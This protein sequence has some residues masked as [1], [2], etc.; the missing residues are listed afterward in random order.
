M[1]SCCLLTLAV[2][3][4][5]G[6]GGLST[7]ALAQTS[8]E[9]CLKQVVRDYDQPLRM[10]PADRIP[11]VLP[12][13]FAPDDVF[14][15]PLVKGRTVLSGSP[16]GYKLYAE[17]T[18]NSTHTLGRPIRLQWLIRMRLW[19][20]NRRGK[21]KQL[22]GKKNQHVLL[23]RDVDR[24]TLAVRQ[25]PGV[26]RFDLEIRKQGR[27]LNHYFQYL[28]VLPRR[29]RSKLKVNQQAF[30]AGEVAIGQLQNLGTIPI[31]VT[32]WAYLAVERFDGNHWISVMSEDMAFQLQE[33]VLLAGRAGRC[34]R[35][36]ISEKTVPGIYR[37]RT[38]IR[39]AHGKRSLS[40]V[41][42]VH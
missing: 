16:I 10:F 39:S 18:G 38:T 6:T 20:V 2:F 37:F 13:S 31:F 24:P 3:A 40:K 15:R 33:V 9:F 30:Q 42:S 28:R 23:L 41:F 5:F 26:Y 32:S 29:T 17:R 22:V 35:F 25:K 4:A 8:P 34:V 14:L 27:L 21:P 36:A 19:S 11:G 7:Y 1:L 12:L